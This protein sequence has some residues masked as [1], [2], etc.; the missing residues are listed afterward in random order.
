M[1]KENID[2]NENN[3]VEEVNEEKEEKEVEEMKAENELNE[4][5]ERV[6][7][8]FQF[9]SINKFIM[10]NNG[11]YHKLNS[12]VQS[13]FS[14]I[15]DLNKKEE[16]DKQSVIEIFNDFA[17]IFLA[18][19]ERIRILEE[20]VEALELFIKCFKE[21]KAIKICLQKIIKKYYA[22][23]FIQLDEKRNVY[24][25]TKK[26]KEYEPEYLTKLLHLLYIR[27]DYFNK[28]AHF[29]GDVEVNKKEVNQIEIEQYIEK[30]NKDLVADKTIPEIDKKLLKIEQFVNNLTFSEFCE[31]LHIANVDKYIQ[32]L[33][34]EQEIMEMLDI[35]QTEMTMEE[36][37]KE[38]KNNKY[39]FK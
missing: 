8:L 1:K 24:V 34:S 7:S 38:L 11:D 33:L 28:K 14:K 2:K 6:N 27:K 30:F 37:Y 26:F 5:K 39:H 13:T 3:E 35:Q 15:N 23:G 9:S 10:D 31:T 12:T 21:R 17:S 25:F 4:K 16:L 18:L 22:L 32:A 29:N 20:K 19:N 36:F